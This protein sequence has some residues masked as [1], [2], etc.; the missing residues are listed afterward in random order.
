MC[1]SRLPRLIQPAAIEQI[2]HLVVHVE[3][4]DI[5]DLRN[6]QPP[7]S[8]LQGAS[9]DLQGSEARREIVQLSIAQRLI[10]KHQHRV[11]IAGPPD[12]GDGGVIEG[13]I[14]VDPGEFG[15]EP[16]SDWMDGDA[17]DRSSRIVR[18]R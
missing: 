17:H 10:A 2:A 12:R 7:P 13:A 8:R 4:G 14:E 5:A 16:V 18:W 1:H 6:R 3:V 11:L 15:R 9:A